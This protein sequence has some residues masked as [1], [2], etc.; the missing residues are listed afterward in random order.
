M[1]IQD[2][3][4][5]ISEYQPSLMIEIIMDAVRDKNPV[6]IDLTVGAGYEHKGIV[7]KAYIR[8]WLG[9]KGIIANEQGLVFQI[10][11][12][13]ESGR[14]EGHMQGVAFN[15]DLFDRRYDLTKINDTMVI[16]DAT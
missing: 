2:L 10:E 1:K 15:P 16:V 8:E 3:L 4:E 14:K 6:R 11:F 12:M 13:A 5:D 7:K 9:V